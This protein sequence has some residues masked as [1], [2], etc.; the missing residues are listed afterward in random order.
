MFGSV[1]VSSP[2]CPSS[3]YR[4]VVSSF[5]QPLCKDNARLTRVDA[6]FVPVVFPAAFVSSTSFALWPCIISVCSCVP[7]FVVVA[8]LRLS[9]TNALFGE[10]QFLYGQLDSPPYL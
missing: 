9:T 5:A 8:L 7:V 6:L 3:H 4:S 10:W 1:V 2:Q